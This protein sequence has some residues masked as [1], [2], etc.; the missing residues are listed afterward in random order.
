MGKSCDD[1]NVPELF[2]ES[3]VSSPE[4]GPHPLVSGSNLLQ[5]NG[6]GFPQLIP[7]GKVPSLHN[8]GYHTH[9]G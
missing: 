6:E 8:L 2:E 9:K 3:L 5:G 7:G 1:H 4:S